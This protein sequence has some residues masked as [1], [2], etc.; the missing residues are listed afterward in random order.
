MTVPG[1][2]GFSVANAPKQ[3]DCRVHV[4]ANV[5]GKGYTLEAAIPF[6]ALGF[7][8]AEGTEIRFDLAVD[9]SENG[10]RRLRQLMW[11]GTDRNSGDR[12]NWGRAVFGK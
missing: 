7:K 8:P 2:P 4:S 6:E 3:H 10:K 1:F 11:N 5:D 12:T 9:D